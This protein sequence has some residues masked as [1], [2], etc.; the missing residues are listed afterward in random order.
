MKVTAKEIDCDCGGVSRQD[1][2]SRTFMIG[3]LRTEVHKIP[4]FVC[5]KCGEVYYDGPSILKIERKLEREA[6][7]V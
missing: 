7:L 1:V 6:A 4:A 2:V 3:G 5:D